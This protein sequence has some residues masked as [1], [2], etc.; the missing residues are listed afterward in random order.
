MGLTVTNEGTCH[1]SITFSAYQHSRGGGMLLC[2]M[3][4]PHGSFW[5]QEPYAKPVDCN[6]DSDV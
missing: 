5:I 6:S 4:S 1:D 3:A 2:R